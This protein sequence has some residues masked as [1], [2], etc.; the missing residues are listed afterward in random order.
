M[1]RHYTLHTR[2]SVDHERLTVVTIYESSVSRK[3]IK[4]ENVYTKKVNK[5]VV[6]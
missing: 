5:V 4:R 1:I 2:K 3:Q 6:E